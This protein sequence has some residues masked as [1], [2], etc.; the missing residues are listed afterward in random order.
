[1]RNF[2]WTTSSDTLSEDLLY[3]FEVEDLSYA[4][5]LPGDYESYLRA[6]GFGDISVADDS[7]WYRR[8][9]REEYELLKGR[10][11]QQ[12]VYLLGKADADHFVENWRAMAI[13][14]E[15]GDHKLNRFL[16]HFVPR[17]Q[18]Y[19]LPAVTP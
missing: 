15:N 14:F 16:I 3:F 8:Q 2:E 9:S 5:E 6:A 13:V 19:Q 4:L 11:Y 18:N 7:G 1:M 17:F 12:M 10:L